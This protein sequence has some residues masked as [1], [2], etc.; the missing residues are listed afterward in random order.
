[1]SKTQLVDFHAAK[2]VVTKYSRLNKPLKFQLKWNDLKVDHP[3]FAE[4]GLQSET[5][6]AFGLGFVAKGLFTNRIAIPIH[7]EK[8]ELV[9]YAGRCPGEPTGGIQKYK[10]SHGFVQSFELFNLTRAIHESPDLPLIVV[11]GFFDCMKLWQLGVRKVVALMD[12]TLST[13]QEELLRQH[14]HSGSRIIVLF[15]EDE[16][17]REGW[18]MD[19]AA[20]L[21]RFAFVHTHQF[22]HEDMQPGHLTAERADTLASLKTTD[23]LDYAI[24]GRPTHSPLRELGY[25]FQ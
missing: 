19:V 20:R 24:V 16:A 8:G 1:M 15:D 2:G 21:S 3:Y 18:C 9:A 23:V 17:G 7:N 6:A 13:V 22:D 14:T 11:E 12:R 10:F 4:R 25:F 5:V